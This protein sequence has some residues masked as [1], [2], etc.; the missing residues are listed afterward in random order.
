MKRLALLA[1]VIWT[2]TGCSSPN[3]VVVYSPHG[4]D[5]L[6][7]YEAKFEAAYPEVD[8]QYVDLGSQEVYERV[9]SVQHRPV[10]DVWWGAPSTMFMQAANEGLLGAYTPTWAGEAEEGGH[11]QADRWYGVHRSPLVIMYNDTHYTSGD[12]PTT[13]DELLDP[14][15]DQKIT[16]RSPLP[17]GTMRTFIGAMILRQETEEAGIEWLKKLHAMTESYQPSPQQLFDRVKRNPELISV[18]LMPDI[19]LQRERNGYP[20]AYVVPAETPV[21]IEGMAIINNAPHRMWAERFYEFVSTQEALIH[22][23]EAYAKVPLRDDIDPAQLPEW[24]SEQEIDA[25]EIDWDAFALNE[26]R[27][28]TLW[29]EEVNRGS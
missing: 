26:Q 1:C 17:S 9:R 13:W 20:F 6:R 10:A 21:I 15:W 24:I 16:L 5:I 18:W 28:V 23:A 8:V 27:W 4:P 14:K 19:P 29:S 11:D 12:L 25:M 2:I 22:Q 3:A 7:D